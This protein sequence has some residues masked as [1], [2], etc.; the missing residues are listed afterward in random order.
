M[1]QRPFRFGIVAG[2]PRSVADLGAAAR[3]LE[4]QGYG[5]MLFPDT[6]GTLSPAIACAAA[7]SATRSLHV[8]PHVLAAPNRTAG[9]VACET[10]TL[11]TLTDKR[12]ELGIGA[13]RPGAETDAAEL[14]M[15]FGSAADRIILVEQTIEAVRAKSPDT[16]I[17]VAAGGRRM[18]RSAGRLADTVTFGVPPRADEKGLSTAVGTLREGAQSRFDELELA[19]N[20]LV[21]GDE[22]PPWILQWSG[23]YL[24]GLRA[25]GSVAL[26]S[27]TTVEMADVLRRRRDKFGISYVSTSEPFADALAPVVQL[28]AGR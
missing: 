13:G 19:Q 22:A 16:R 2:R 4:S 28:L 24:A 5:V 14:G 25:V 1:A 7:A 23:S 8:G 18:L 11:H 27:G 17:L 12:Y 20:L 9:Q 15:P 6:L 3:R 26:L 10:K 21:V